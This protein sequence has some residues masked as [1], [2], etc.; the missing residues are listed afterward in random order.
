MV[1]YH[2]DLSDL[3]FIKSL[4][5]ISLNKIYIH[6][7]INQMVLNKSTTLNLKLIEFN[8]F[9]LEKAGDYYWRFKNEIRL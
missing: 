3:K 2:Y 6:Y 8:E 5:E 4:D 9:T 7:W 1:K